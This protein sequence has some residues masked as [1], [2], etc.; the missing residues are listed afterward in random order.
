MFNNYTNPYMYGGSGVG[1]NFGTNPYYQPYQ[2]QMPQ[3]PQMQ[4]AAQPQAQTQPQV[5]PQMNA[6]NTNKIY[7][8]GTEDVRARILP[9]NSDYI[10]LDNDKAMIYQKVVD[11]KGQFEVKTFDI[12][13]HVEPETAKT[14]DS[15]NLSNY[16]L[17]SDLDPLRAEIKA[18]NDKITKLN[19]QSQIN[20]IKKDTKIP[21]SEEK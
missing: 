17:K 12:V 2:T 14:P 6:T 5:Q 15:T 1:M 11:G 13:P 21:K 8:N 18:L 16:V 20:D 10:F 9:P 4:Q 19:V 3:Q 7:V